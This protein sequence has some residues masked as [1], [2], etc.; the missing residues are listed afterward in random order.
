MDWKLYEKEIFDFFKGTYPDAEINFNQ[1]L[2]G[3][4]SKIERQID[5]LIESYVAG[6]RIRL[7][8]D[9]KF[10][11]TKIDV[12]DVE[13]FIS[14]VEDVDAKQGIL[15]TRMGYSPGAINRAYYGPT[16]IE[17]DI[18]NFEELDQFQGIGGIIHA[19]KHGAVI[20]APFGWVIDARKRDSFLASLYQRGL[21]F[22]G[23]LENK[24]W[25]YVNI[26][27]KDTRIKT[28][29]DLVT[30]QETYTKTEF[31]TAQ[32]EYDK[33]ITRHDSSRTLLRTIVIDNYPTNEYT[34]FIEFNEFL[35]F[36]VF[37]TPIE[38]RSKNI[39]KL[40]FLLER[41]LPIQVDEQSVL[42]SNLNR[43]EFF[44]NKATDTNVKAELLIGQ[45]EILTLLKR[46]DQ[47]LE[48]YNE[49]ISILNTSYGAIIGKI[50]IGLLTNLSQEILMP[51]VDN[52]FH[53]QP[54]NP[55]VCIKLM[56]MFS[57]FDRM[58]DL[59]YF[60]KHGCKEFVSNKEAFGNFNYH[61]GL[62]YSE[63]KKNK[64]AEE[65]FQF[66]KIAFSESVPLDH[67]VFPQIDQNLKKLKTENKA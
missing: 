46:Y 4:Y 50:Q 10:F 48:K 13:S 36:F 60:L 54:T 22:E 61:L 35:V 38:L 19:G 31:P 41:T 66:A 53:L 56:D 9:A 34:G 33:T 51:L 14:M 20:P 59:I 11:N 16:D 65:H 55:T 18:L 2:K 12:K 23:A 1:L 57:E 17:L 15:I 24:E 67:Y 7:I 30:L 6:K 45:G 49:S 29:E 64:L 26:F 32:F 21:S 8:V 40:E 44:Y 42:E 43:L 28:L 63:L 27:R 52:F 47:A 25:A 37:F 5:V 62:L 3:R 58:D 39:R